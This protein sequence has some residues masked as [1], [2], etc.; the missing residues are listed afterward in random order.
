MRTRIAIA[1][2]AAA[3]TAGSVYADAAVAA[4]PY[5]A[6]ATVQVTVR[7]VTSSGHAASGFTVKGDPTGSLDCSDGAPSQGAV[8]KNILQCFPDAEYAI[9]CWK[10]ATPHRVLCMRNPAK[11]QL[12]KIPFTGNFGHSAPPTAQQLAPLRLVLD[13]G[14]KC[15]IR[16][17]GAWGSLKH[18]PQWQGAY[19]CTKG[20]DV[21]L[22]PSSSHNG[23]DESH[24]A[25]TVHTADASTAKQTVRIRKVVKAYF[26]GTAA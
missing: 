6:A 20:G 25:W 11:H 14:A 5:S 10:S 15:S 7:P 24:A 12:A 9:A 26:V 13:N 3:L 21:W 17:G 4:A 22:L 18:H 8:D 1:I 19:S 2:A 16:D 23:V